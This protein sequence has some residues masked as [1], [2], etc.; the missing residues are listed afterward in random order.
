MSN[1]ALRCSK[2]KGQHHPAECP[3]EE[4]VHDMYVHGVVIERDGKR[5]D[6]KDFYKQGDKMSNE[7]ELEEIVKVLLKIKHPDGLPFLPNHGSSLR[8]CYPELD[9]FAKEILVFK[10][11]KVKIGLKKRNG[12]IGLSTVNGA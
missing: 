3:K 9:T 6:P 2:C 11:K 8:S 12:S 7:R 5:I 10:N 1:N 4:Y